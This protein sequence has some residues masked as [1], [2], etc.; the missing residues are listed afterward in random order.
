MRLKNQAVEME[1]V[2]ARKLEDTVNTFSNRGRAS[3]PKP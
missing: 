1:A 2:A 3:S